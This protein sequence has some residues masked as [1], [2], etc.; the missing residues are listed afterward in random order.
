M[1]SCSFL[2]CGRGGGWQ[3]IWLLSQKKN[4]KKIQVTQFLV[5]LHTKFPASPMLAAY[6]CPSEENLRRFRMKFSFVK[7]F[8]SK[9]KEKQ[10]KETIETPPVLKLHSYALSFPCWWASLMN[11]T[12][13]VK[14]LSVSF[15]ERNVFVLQHPQCPGLGG[16]LGALLPHSPTAPAPVVVEQRNLCRIFTRGYF[17]SCNCS[18]IAGKRKLDINWVVTVLTSLALL[19]ALS[20][21]YH[22]ITSSGKGK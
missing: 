20:V 9:W 12:N 13:N 16:W 4:P 18:I 15:P 22:R 8:Y 21:L 6:S 10:E 3:V 1:H 7:L 5:K 19:L 14:S 2:G 17:G 11:W